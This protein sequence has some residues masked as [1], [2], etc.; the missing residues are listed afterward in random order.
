MR[1]RSS[2]VATAKLATS[3]PNS[4]GC[5]SGCRAV[6]RQRPSASRSGVELMGPEFNY[7]IP[8][9]GYLREHAADRLGHAGGLLRA[10]DLDRPLL[11]DLVPAAADLVDR[12]H[13]GAR[14]DAAA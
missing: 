11:D 5:H 7:R 13:L 12:K 4:P 1:R 9:E 2:P 3:L 14:A 10:L 6:Q 8:F